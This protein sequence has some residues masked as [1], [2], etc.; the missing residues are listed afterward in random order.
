[1]S[2]VR[3]PPRSVSPLRILFLGDITS[4]NFF[5][6]ISDS[7]LS[8]HDIELVVVL[9]LNGSNEMR[10]QVLAQYASKYPRAKFLEYSKFSFIQVLQMCHISCLAFDRS[11]VDP[12]T[13]N[14]WMI[15]SIAWGVPS[16]VSNTIEYER[17]AKEIGIDYA[18][19]SNVA[20][21][22]GIIDTLRSPQTRAVYMAAAQ[23]EVWLRYSPESV[24][25]V[26]LNK[27]SGLKSPRISS[28]EIQTILRSDRRE[29][30]RINRNPMK[31]FRRWARKH[32]PYPIKVMLA[33]YV[34]VLSADIY[35]DTRRVPPQDYQPLRFDPTINA[36]QMGI[37][38]R[39]RQQGSQVLE[40]MPLIDV[41]K[42]ALR[43]HTPT[44]VLQIGCGHGHILS[45]LSNEFNVVGCDGS[46]NL[47]RSY[48]PG[49]NV[50]EYDIA[51]ATGDFEKSHL[52]EWETV[53]LYG[54]MRNLMTTPLQTAYT[55][56]NLLLL[57]SKK[58]IV[59]DWPEVCL[60]MQQFSDSPKFEYHQLDTKMDR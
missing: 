41:I 54:V 29:A 2:P 34:S 24:A 9:E 42:T 37:Q 30:I 53:F 3:L 13:S 57:A 18:I 58:I 59:W 7:L 8:L 47:L 23:S 12:F 38:E 40:T 45:E 21:L 49:L 20:E 5:D 1:M 50:F 6:S 39:L 35:S 14:R 25:K 52:Y 10:Q 16:V 11:N 51:Q 32:M 43:V 60:R 56:N 33:P 4:E 15:T 48:L 46:S 28:T 22:Y 17:T 44:S 19:F 55:M 36:Y 31:Q 27:L 26:F